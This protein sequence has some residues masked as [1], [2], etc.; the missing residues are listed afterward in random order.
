MNIAFALFL[1]AAPDEPTTIM[2]HRAERPRNT[3]DLDI[4]REMGT[5]DSN[6]SKLYQERQTITNKLQAAA[7]RTKSLLDEY[8]ASIEDEQELSSQLRSIDDRIAALANKKAD[9]ANQLKK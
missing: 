5:A 4:R 3:T 7:S 9:L 8:H 2:Q 1:L 6:I